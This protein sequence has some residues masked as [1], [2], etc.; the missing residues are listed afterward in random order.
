MTTRE[1][2]LL[3]FT[4]LARPQFEAAGAP[5]PD[6]VRVSVGFPSKGNRSKVIGE[7]WYSE[8]SQ[9]HAVEVF[10]RPSLQSD[11]A[12]V[13][14]VLTHE[15]V[16][17]ALGKGQGHGPKFRKVAQALGLVGKMTATVAGPGW[18]EWADAILEKLGPLPGA[19]LDDQAQLEGGKKT[20]TTRYLKVTCDCCGWTARVTAKH[21]GLEGGVQQTLSCPVPTCDGELVQS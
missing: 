17:A 11:S 20:Q 21:L 2:W 19:Q 15:L 13:A 10:I 6:R 8:A 16:H 3:A 4:D 1:G 14:D 5:L 7:C 12:R 9:D 18:H